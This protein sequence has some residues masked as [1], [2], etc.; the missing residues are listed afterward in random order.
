MDLQEQMEKLSEAQKERI[1]MQYLKVRNKA[2]EK[3][4]KE[5]KD[6][7]DFI[8]K[9]R[10]FAKNYYQNNKEKKFEYYDNNKEKIRLRARFNYYKQRNRLQDYLLKYSEEANNFMTE[11]EINEITNNSE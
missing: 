2:N 8:E 5:L 10:A 3:Y 9:N 4:K 6:N 7:P 1:I 11:E